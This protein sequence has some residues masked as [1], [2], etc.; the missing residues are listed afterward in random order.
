MSKFTKNEIIQKLNEC[1]MA[2][3][4]AT[5]RYLDRNPND[6]YP[7]GFAW[8]IVKDGRSALAKVLKEHFGANKA[9]GERGVQVWD[10]ANLN[11]QAMYAKIAG[12]RAFNEALILVGLVENVEDVSYGYRID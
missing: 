3:R 1:F 9:Y 10:P 11:T 8:C 4:M 2:A 12:A 6:W 5:Q 7:C